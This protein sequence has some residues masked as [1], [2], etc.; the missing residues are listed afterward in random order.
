MCP[1]WGTTRACGALL[2]AGGTALHLAASAGQAAVVAALLEHGAA[3]HARD[4][5]GQDSLA[6]ARV[7][8]HV[9]TVA[10]LLHHAEVAQAVRAWRWRWCPGA[11]I[12][13]CSRA[14]GACTSGA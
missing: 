3:A 14:A 8:D 6:L 9:D 5:S 10:I 12:S 11:R 1:R 2:Q 4:G 13:C 7:G